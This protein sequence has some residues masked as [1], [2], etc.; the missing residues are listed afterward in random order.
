MKL[1]LDSTQKTTT[2]GRLNE[3]SSVLS[4]KILIG[5]GESRHSLLNR[6][7]FH[8]PRITVGK[9]LKGAEKTHYITRDIT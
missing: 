9:K 3:K 1:T 2:Q 5:E 7:I 8:T 4:E 6:Y